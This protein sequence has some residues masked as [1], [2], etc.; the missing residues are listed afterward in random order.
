MICLISILISLIISFTVFIIAIDFI[1]SKKR[2]MLILD[3]KVYYFKTKED[4]D[5][6]LEAKRT[7]KNTCQ[8]FVEVDS[9]YIYLGSRYDQ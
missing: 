7:Y 5:L 6:F 4:M 8:R 2:Y 1:Q 9:K 3:N